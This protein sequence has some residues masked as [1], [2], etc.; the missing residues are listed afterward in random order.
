MKKILLLLIVILN[1]S[2]KASAQCT[3]SGSPNVNSSTVSC[4]SFSA[5]TVIYVGDGVNPTNL[6]MNQ[7][8]NF[9][10]LGPIQFVIRNNANIDFSSGNYD[11]SLPAGSSIVVES[12]GNIGAGSNCSASDLIKIGSIKVASCNGGGGAITDFPTLVSGGGYNVAIAS[13]TSICGSG[14]STITASK[15]P[16]PTSSTTFKF[17]TVASGGTAVY[18]TTTNTSPYTVTYTTPVLSATTNYYV[19]AITNSNGDTTPRKLVTVTVNTIPTTP[20]VTVTHPTCS[21][22]TGTITVNSPTAG[23]M[24]YSI[25]G[26]TYTNTSGVFSGLSAGSYNVTAKSAAGCIS[27]VAVATV[28]PQPTIPVQPTLGSLTQPTCNVATGSFVI[29]NYNA[30]YFYSVTP[31]AGVLISGATVTAPAGTYTVTA[32]LLPCSSIES[33]SITISSQPSN[34][35]NGSVW[36]NGV[37]TLGQRLVFSGNYSSTGNVS[38]CSCQV[39]SGTVVFNAGHTLTIAHEVTVNPGGLLTFED[40]A[41]LVQINDT[42]VNSGNITYKRN[43]TPMKLYDYG[44]WSSPVSNATL[45]QLAGDSYFYSFSPITNSYVYHTAATNMALGV[46]YL[47]RTPENLIYNP[48]LIL[49][50]TFVGT[51]NNGVISTPIIKSTATNNLIG[52]PYPSAIDIDLFLTDP[53][54]SGI[55]NG[56]IFL[57]THNTAITNN[58]YSVNDYAKYNLTG[59]VATASAALSGG[60]VPT[61]KVAAGQGFFIEANTALANGT[62]SATFK[63]SMRISGNN[64]QFFR[65]SNSNT[66]NSND[67]GSVSQSLE[68]HRVWLSVSNNEGAYNEMLVGYIQNATND[69][70]ALFDGKTTVVGNPVSI[71]TT[72][73][74]TDLAIQGKALPFSTE[75]VVPFGYATTFDGELT[76]SLEKFDGLFDNQNIYL[77]D[78]STGLY[79]DLKAGNY[80]FTTLSGTFNDRFELRFDNQA[81]GIDTNT[82]FN[83]DVKVV[84]NNQGLSVYCAST[85][86]NKVEVF[87][88]LGKLLFSQNNLETNAFEAIQWQGVS[89]MLLVK[90]T[91]ENGQTHTK[92]TLIQ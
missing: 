44:Y 66:V 47:S 81:L 10:C 63:N 25:N 69:F 49:Q 87:D 67:G 79:H 83:N 65:T 15:N 28:N 1:F 42:S 56:T 70:D 45:S 64:N 19:E 13:A 57:W 32:T 24:T 89:Q 90:V 2:Y 36:S 84:S 82:V 37:P 22:A 85:P 72:V 39:T 80:N 38:G 92:K 11:L 14:T 60:A 9:G 5:C 48:T 29:T 31:S 40:T 78:K 23:G 88:V 71:Y 73:G 75:D 62:Y 34:T 33:S 91:L 68:K 50:S 58:N 27:S 59:G 17:Y 3:I 86:I 61:G 55:V 41:S 4:S 26:S 30:S 77:L 74:T 43:T 51:P 52:N 53:A 6:V 54:N 12:G 16:A 7:N 8:L 35:W 76:I 18:T 46:G 21:L 20:T